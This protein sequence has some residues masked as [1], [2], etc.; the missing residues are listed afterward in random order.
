[1]SPPLRVS[2]LTKAHA[3]SR[4]QRIP[5]ADRNRRSRASFIPTNPKPIPDSMPERSTVSLRIHSAVR[6][7]W[8]LPDD[9]S[10]F[11]GLVADIRTHGILD[12]LRI[13]ED[14]AVVDGRHRL[15]AAKL[16]DLDMVPVEVLRAG[17]EPAG[18][19]ISS[20]TARRHL[21]GKGQL[22]YAAYPL[23]AARHRELQESS[24]R[25]LRRGP[26]NSQPIPD[27]VPA[28]AAALGIS[29]DTFQQA[30]RLHEIFAAD[31][32]LKAEWEPKIMAED[33]PI[34]LGAAIAGIAGQAAST[35]RTP[36]RNSALARFASAW[37]H[38]ATP[39]SAWSKWTDAERDKAAETVRETVAKLPDPLLDVIRDALRSARRARGTETI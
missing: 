10:R 21:T 14:G 7:A 28:I 19:A 23:F 33:N 11:L 25:G 27:S 35:D 36:A 17:L 15:R 6:S 4:V 26:Q 18:V 1:M 22:A 20:L 3:L 34:G 16:L 13:T 31:A 30:A 37:S 24:S 8:E 9:D 5:P 38:V 39:A 32:E 12:P 29:V 2:L